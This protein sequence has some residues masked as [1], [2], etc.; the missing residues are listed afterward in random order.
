[1]MAVMDGSRA[2]VARGQLVA[3]RVVPAGAAAGRVSRQSSKRCGVRVCGFSPGP[4][5][6]DAVYLSGIRAA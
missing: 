5:R 6:A 1:M 4:T 3:P 2:K